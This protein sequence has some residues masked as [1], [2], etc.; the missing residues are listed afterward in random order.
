MRRPRGEIAHR[1][2]TT[3]PHIPQRKCGA[4]SASNVCYRGTLLVPPA[5]G[6]KALHGRAGSANRRLKVVEIQRD[7][8]PVFV[9][10]NDRFTATAPPVRLASPV[11]AAPSSVTSQPAFPGGPAPSSAW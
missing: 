8:L 9:I 6:C 10:L 1:P 3:K 2:P 5:I 7:R 4:V 11:Y